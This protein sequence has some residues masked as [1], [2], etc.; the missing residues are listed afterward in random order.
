MTTPRN[1][2]PTVEELEPFLGKDWAICRRTAG[3]L[4]RYGPDCLLITRSEFRKAQKMALASR[5]S[6]E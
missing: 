3:N 2:Y 6:N 1:D 5:R 4:L